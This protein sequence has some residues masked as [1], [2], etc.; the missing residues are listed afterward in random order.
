MKLLTAIVILRLGAFIVGCVA[1]SA[2]S[3]MGWP[4]AGWLLVPT[5][6]AGLMCS[7][8]CVPDDDEK[9]SSVS[10]GERK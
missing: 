9:K 2:A 10:S 6:L 8:L 7:S 5:V 4:Y 1:F 3:Y